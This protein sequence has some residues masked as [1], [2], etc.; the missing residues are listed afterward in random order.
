MRHELQQGKTPSEIYRSMVR[1]SHDPLNTSTIPSKRQIYYQSQ[2][3]Q[4]EKLPSD[5]VHSFQISSIIIRKL[6]IFVEF[7]VI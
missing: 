6:V 5:E 4:M 1:E 7:M 2:K 3:V